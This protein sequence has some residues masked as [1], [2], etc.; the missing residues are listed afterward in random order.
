M[1]NTYSYSDMAKEFRGDRT[2]ER[3]VDVIRR[4]VKLHGPRLVQEQ[5]ASLAPRMPVDRGAYRRSFRY[6]DI[7]GGATA[8]SSAPHAAIIEEGRRPG[9]RMPPVAV[10]AAWVRRKRLVEGSGAARARGER[11]AAFLIARAI[12]VRGLPARHVLALASRK[13]DSIVR[14]ELGKARP[15]G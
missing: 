9:A 8:Y 5:I 15:G 10:I 1:P 7:P 4:T 11:Q 3:A 14:A 12:K 13:L 6:E 2:V